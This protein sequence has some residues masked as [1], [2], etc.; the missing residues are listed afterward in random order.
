MEVEVD[1]VALLMQVDLAFMALLERLDSFVH[2]ND[3]ERGFLEDQRDSHPE[4]D[5][6]EML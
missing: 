3:V 2:F 6:H 1:Q 4:T 5:Q